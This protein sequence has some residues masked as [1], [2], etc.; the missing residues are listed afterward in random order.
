MEIAAGLG[1][2]SPQIVRIPTDFICEKAPSLTGTL[3][4]DKIHPGVFDNS[5]IKQH[6]PG[7]KCCKTVRAA[8]HESVEWLR[9][10]PEAR[11]VDLELD[12]LMEDVIAAW[13]E[14][15]SQ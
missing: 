4:G 14:R 13:R 9:A 8:L 15:C 11:K 2:A 5:K 10:H 6:V 7:W 1:V 3:K 12:R